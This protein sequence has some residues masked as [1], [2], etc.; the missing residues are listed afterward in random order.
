MKRFRAHAWEQPSGSSHRW[1]EPPGAESGDESNSDSES[2]PTAAEC[3]DEFVNML[4]SLYMGG[5]LPAQT[6]CQL[7][8]YA[9]GF[10]PHHEL[11]RLAYKPGQPSG[12]YQRRL[13]SVLGFKAER[14][15]FYRLRVPGHH[16]HDLSRTTHRVPVRVAHEALNDEIVNDPSCSVRLR[17]LV[18]ER[19]LPPSYFSHPVVSNSDTLVVPTAL[20]VDGLPYSHTDS[21]IGFWMINLVTGS[22][23]LLM[24]IRKR[25][26]CRC[27]CRH[28]CSLDAIL[29][30]LRW[31][32]HSLA[33]GRYPGGRHDGLPWD[34]EDEARRALSGQP[35]RLK[36]CLLYI[37]GDWMEY[38]STFGFPAWSS[39]SRPCPFCVVPGG[40]LYDIRGLTPVQ[41]PY[42]LNDHRDWE[43]ACTRCEIKVVVTADV[44]KLLVP[45]LQYDKRPHG[46]RGLALRQSLPVVGLLAGDR[47]EPSES[48]PDVG[49]FTALS[50]FP[51]TC[52]FWRPSNETMVQHRNPIFL[53]NW[54][55]LYA[56]P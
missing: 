7:C 26:L 33:T 1:E 13:D 52:T 43:L 29:R 38:C 27:G 23:H 47:L 25:V 35:L 18:Q 44:H 46:S 24:A 3:M 36:A 22:R 34:P 53:P 50:N 9:N 6:L 10:F 4:I 31:C 51:I 30:F 32:F 8:Y 15:A 11:R 49:L 56:T 40:S 20:F 48:L 2:E 45:L 14:D 19:A 16:R 41:F 17:E 12:H 42:H 55:L 21:V 28:W 37:K 5:G 39:T 54:A